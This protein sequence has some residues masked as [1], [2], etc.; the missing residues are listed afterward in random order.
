MLVFSNM[1]WMIKTVIHKKSLIS[2]LLVF[3]TCS[4][5]FGQSQDLLLSPTAASG[6]SITFIQIRT[7]TLFHSK[8]IMSLLVLPKKNFSRFHLEIGY[9]KSDL[10]PTSFFVMSKNAVAAINGSYFD[11]DNGGSVTYL[12]IHDTVISRT[13]PS[14][15]K[16]AKPVSLINGAIVIGKDSSVLI[17]PAKTD[18][19]YEQSNNE[20]AVLVSGSL[21]L[22]NSQ[23]LEL[24]KMELVTDRNPRTCLCETK[25][26]LA[27]I[28]I[29]GRRKEAAGMSLAE[30]QQY[31]KKIGCVDALNLDGGGS[32]T[33]WIKGKGIVNYPSDSSGERPVANALLIIKNVIGR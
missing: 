18:Q 13:R 6:D 4:F 25:E 17:E 19:F 5:C 33:M 30:T 23:L 26:S 2:I 14:N 29:D 21:L 28:T 7:D 3:L 12:E 24:P 10:K 20:I 11:R 31:L 32:T 16:W 27:F 22:Y 15:L 9:S 1:L 8:Q